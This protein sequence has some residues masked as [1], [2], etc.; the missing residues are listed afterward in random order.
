MS[1]TAPNGDA[2]GTGPG[3]RRTV[4]IVWPLWLAPVVILGGLV[5]AVEYAPDSIESFYTDTAMPFLI[6]YWIGLGFTTAWRLARES[7]LRDNT[8]PGVVAA[9]GILSAVVLLY[10]LGG[11]SVLWEDPWIF[12]VA[13][14]PGFALA[15]PFF[16]R[17]LLRRASNSGSSVSS[18]RQGPNPES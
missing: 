16:E 3:F 4:S 12:G 14:A 17:W 8:P 10:M 11:I 7:A 13:V 2:G 18:A 1:N 9:V 15:R 5:L 6:T